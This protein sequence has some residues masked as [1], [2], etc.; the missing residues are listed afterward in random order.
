MILGTAS[1]MPPERA[2]GNIAQGC[3]PLLPILCR[4]RVGVFLLIQDAT[5][6]LC[7]WEQDIF[8]V[9]CPVTQLDVIIEGYRI[10]VG[11]RFQDAARQFDSGRFHA[12]PLLHDSLGDRRGHRRQVWQ[13]SL[14]LKVV[15]IFLAGTT[16][17]CGRR[18][19]CGNNRV[20]HEAFAADAIILD[21]VTRPVS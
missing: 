9:D 2:R 3:A 15:V 21:Y 12:Q 20:V 7:E 10:T 6:N 11:K 16:A 1:Y 14:F 5:G 17:N 4:I 19:T 13:A 18:I 8:R